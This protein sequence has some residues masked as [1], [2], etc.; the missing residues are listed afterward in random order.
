MDALYVQRDLSESRIALINAKE[1]QLTV[2]VNAYQSFGGGETL[3][4]HR[5]KE[6]TDS[7]PNHAQAA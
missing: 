6:Y 7:D 4:Y 5:S 2:I 3:D 1:K